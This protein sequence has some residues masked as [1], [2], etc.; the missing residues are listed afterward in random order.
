[1]TRGEKEEEKKESKEQGPDFEGERFELEITKKNGRKQVV[2][3]IR[4]RLPYENKI[5]EFV[6]RELFFGEQA[7]IIQEVANLQ[8]VGGRPHAKVNVEA[9]TISPVEKALH[10]A[11]FP[12]GT[13]ETREC[14]RE[15]EGQTGTAL[16]NAVDKLNDLGE[17][18]KKI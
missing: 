10:A 12:L 11:P 13:S 4:L 1:M 9:Y 18:K 17:I 3:A 2:H 16:Y 5:E 15:L 6:V 8:V 14:V 7:D